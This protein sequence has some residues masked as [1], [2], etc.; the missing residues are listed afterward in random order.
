[1]EGGIGDPDQ[2]LLFNSPLEAGVRSLVILDATYPLGYDLSEL[3]WLDHLV[4]HTA[5]IDGPPSLHPKLAH[6]SGELLVR[7]HLVEE[8]LTAMRRLH[9]IVIEASARGLIYKASDD[10]VAVI[11]HLRTDYARVLKE[12]AH[13]LANMIEAMSPED[14]K[15]LVDRRIGRWRI[16]F[17]GTEGWGRG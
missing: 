14:L 12:R 13:W 15:G 10:G 9:L 3:T 16:E 2:P 11:E 8:G 17:N 1:M 7:R 4:V 5:D 6:R